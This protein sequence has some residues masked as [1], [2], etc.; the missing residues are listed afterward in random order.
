MRGFP[1]HSFAANQAWLEIVMA[2]LDLIAW[3]KMLGFKD[4]PD[5]ARCEVA[6]FRYRVLHV[7]ARI[8]SSGRRTRLRIDRTWRWA[9]PIADAWHQIRA[10]FT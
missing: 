3:S 10:A 9:T 6:T 8:S 5:L 7:A 4:H 1:C 2:A